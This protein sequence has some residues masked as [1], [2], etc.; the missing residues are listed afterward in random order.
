ML[1]RLFFDLADPLRTPRALR[2]TLLFDPNP[3]KSRAKDAKPA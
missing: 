1:F 2:E 3:E